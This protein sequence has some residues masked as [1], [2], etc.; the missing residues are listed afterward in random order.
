[1]FL[2]I[3]VS[4]R[5]EAV[6]ADTACT[7]LLTEIDPENPDIVFGL[8]DLR[9]GF[10]ELGSMSLTEIAALLGLPV[11]RDLSFEATKNLSAYDNAAAALGYIST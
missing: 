3:C 6:F 5:Y 8:C 7:W 11:E 1:M 4:F 10:P 9:M 2:S